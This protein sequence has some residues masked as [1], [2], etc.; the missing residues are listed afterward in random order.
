MYF[1]SLYTHFSLRQPKP[2]LTR[3]LTLFCFA[4]LSASC[5][6][7]LYSVFIS[8][9]RKAWMASWT[10]VSTDSTWILQTKSIQKLDS[11][12]VRAEHTW[13]ETINEIK[14]VIG[15]EYHY[16][17][18]NAQFLLFGLFIWVVSSLFSVT[19]AFTILY[20]SASLFNHKHFQRNQKHF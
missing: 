8:L 17:W 1:F 3:M 10:R 19:T 5:E 13:R 9:L 12:I 4:E 14:S 7:K 18:R 6:I 16:M 11:F 2:K 15:G 20:I